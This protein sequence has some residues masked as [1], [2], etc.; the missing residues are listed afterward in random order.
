K[1][2]LRDNKLTRSI[3]RIR[4]DMAEIN[5]GQERIR[6]GQKEVR[7]KFEEISKET[8]KLKEET[9]IISKQSAANQVRL[10]LMFQI[11]KARSENDARRDAV[12]TQILR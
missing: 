7:E 1:R 6:D 4:A 12:L 10:D 2:K 5:E 11:I 8:A 9:N 3:K